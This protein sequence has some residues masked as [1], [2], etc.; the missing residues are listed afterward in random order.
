MFLVI[1]NNKRMRKKWKLWDLKQPCSLELQKKTWLMCPAAQ[2]RKGKKSLPVIEK[3]S[4]I[5]KKD[6]ALELGD[7]T[8]ANKTL[9]HRAGVQGSQDEGYCAKV[10]SLKI[11]Q[12]KGTLN[13]TD[14][15]QSIS[16]SVVF[17][18]K[19]IT[20]KCSKKQE[21]K[22][23]NLREVTVRTTGFSRK[24]GSLEKRTEIF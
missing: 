6:R 7:I 14:K 5:W 9:N 1:H 17:K 23:S 10:R 12:L 20:N 18:L 16:K 4:K 15:K 3:I 19:T 22:D 13:R 11:S 24:P 2:W 21:G 8:R